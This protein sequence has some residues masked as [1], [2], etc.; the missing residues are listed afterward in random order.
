MNEEP[1]QPASSLSLNEIQKRDSFES[2]P[3]EVEPV[4]AEPPTEQEMT[5]DGLVVTKR[6]S[7][8]IHS[9]RMEKMWE[10]MN[11]KEQSLPQKNERREP[12]Q[13]Q[14]SEL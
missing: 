3:M 9:D 5:D 6:A 11:R 13:K 12:L 10:E 4:A 2:A 1:Q 8:R 7:H 14:T